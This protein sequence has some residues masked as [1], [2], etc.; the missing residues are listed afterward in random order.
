MRDH[1]NVLRS[2][3][4]SSNEFEYQDKHGKASLKTYQQLG[5]SLCGV[6]PPDDLVYRLGA[7]GLAAHWPSPQ[8]HWRRWKNEVLDSEGQPIATLEVVDK[9]CRQIIEGKRKQAATISLPTDARANA[10]IER[11]TQC[12][13]YHE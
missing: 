5:G 7:F 9:A 2:L 13:A 12:K 4:A 3:Q 1:S 11:K 6:F 8:L 10:Q